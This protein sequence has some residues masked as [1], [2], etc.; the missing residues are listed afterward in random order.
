MNTIPNEITG[1]IIQHAMQ[2]VTIGR[3]EESS[4]L[5]GVLGRINKTWHGIVYGTGQYWERVFVHWRMDMAHIK[6]VCEMARPNE[7]RRCHLHISTETEA[8]PDA[9]DLEGIYDVVVIS[10]WSE[11]IAYHVSPLV[12]KTQSLTVYTYTPRMVLSV[13]HDIHTQYAHALEN[14]VCYSTFSA[15]DDGNYLQ[16]I[17][18]AHLKQISVSGISPVAFA[19]GGLQHIKTLRMFSIP[20]PLSWDQVIRILRNCVVI[21]ELEVVDITCKGNPGGDIIE[22][23]TLRALKV[24]ISE[25]GGIETVELVY[26]P[27]LAYLSL[28]GDEDAPWDRVVHHMRPILRKIKR[29][30]IGSWAYSTQVKDLWYCIGLWAYSTQ[31]KDFVSELHS[32][33][34]LDVRE[35]STH[36][37][38]DIARANGPGHPSLKALKSWIVSRGISDSQVDSLF[39]WPGSKVTEIFEGMQE[40]DE[41]SFRKWESSGTGYAVFPIKGTPDAL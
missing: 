8:E 27:G 38:E 14:F 9:D 41:P 22:F 34:V 32:T 11:A 16:P 33:E 17:L 37:L 35:G 20:L 25:A 21:E 6:H 10:A 15:T 29:C 28:R 30:C 31:V 4:R 1:E 23:P 24:D 12:Y 39:N 36:F 7:R 40:Q 19:P 26:A 13:L 3:R 18:S 5:K 2:E